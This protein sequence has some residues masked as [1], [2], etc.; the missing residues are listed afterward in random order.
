MGSQRHR[1]PEPDSRALREFA[2]LTGVA[3]IVLFGLV[4]P[5]MFD[6][7]W[8]VWP[9]IIAI[10]LMLTGWFA[11]LVL[12]PIYSVWLQFGM[13]IGKITT[14]IIMGAVFYLVITP[15]GLLRNLFG[16]DPMARKFNDEASYRILSKKVTDE[17]VEKP[18]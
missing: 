14:P 5:W 10:P 7:N 17:D 15:M 3:I 12:R 13:L 9:W 8:P 1:L 16:D 4:L 2:L 6:L 11:P 18:F